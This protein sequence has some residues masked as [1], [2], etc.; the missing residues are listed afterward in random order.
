MLKEGQKLDQLLVPSSGE[1]A[2][3]PTVK[4]ACRGPIIGSRDGEPQYSIS[5]IHH[6]WARV[7]KDDIRNM[8]GEHIPFV[9]CDALYKSAAGVACC[10]LANEPGQTPRDTP[11]PKY[12]P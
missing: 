9:E 7:H 6:V 11:C 10:A 2:S 4:I 12:H 3:H 1:T 5:D 8:R